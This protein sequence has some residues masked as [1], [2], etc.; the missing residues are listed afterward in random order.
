MAA[1]REG[2]NQYAP[3]AGVPELREAVAQHQAAHYG[4][5][6]D[7]TREVLV[8]TG[9][10]EAIAAA[11]LAFVNPGDEVVV[12]EPFYDS[13]VA[14]IQ[15]AG[16]VRRPVTLRSPDFR[17]DVDELRAAVT[18]R[19]TAVLVNSPH[20]PT[21]TVLD[22]DELEA[23]AAVAREHDLVV[24]TDE[25]YEHLVFDDRAHVPL[26]TLD[27]MWDRTVSISSKTFSFTGWKVGWVTGPA[28]LVRAVESAKQWLTFS[29]A[30]RCSRRSPTR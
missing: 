9:A 19:T 18:D 1:L 27:G 10:T 17:L 11:I 13:Y 12:L 3:G 6:L 4:V 28:P 22:R 24:I 14:T 15:M 16:G 30:P 20:N 7:P 5:E 29:S 21:G 2:R 26:C 25:V 8:T 23:I